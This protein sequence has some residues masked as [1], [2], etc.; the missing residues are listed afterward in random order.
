[1]FVLN[2]DFCWTFIFRVLLISP[3]IRTYSNIWF[4]YTVNNFILRQETLLFFGSSFF[5]RVFIWTQFNSAT[6]PIHIKSWVTFLLLVL[7]KKFKPNFILTKLNWKAAATCCERNCNYNINSA[8]S[9]DR[10]ETSHNC[11]RNTQ[12]N[13][14]HWNIRNKNLSYIK[15][16][17]HEAYV[18]LNLEKWPLS[19]T[20]A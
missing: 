4:E 1:M 16:N 6:H 2:L 3:W 19:C 12:W 20:A 10:V 14:V 13:T 17:T 7:R 15:G 5:P 8:R 11:Q 9:L 18:Q